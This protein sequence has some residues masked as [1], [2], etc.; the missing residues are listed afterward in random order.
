[1]PT[2][3]LIT[4]P[5]HC[6]PLCEIVKGGVCMRVLAAL[7]TIIILIAGCA[8]QRPVLYPNEHTRRVG[9]VAADQDIDD[10][11]K[12]AKEPGAAL[13]VEPG[14]QSGAI[15]DLFDKFEL[16]PGQKVFVNKCLRDKGYDPV[17]WK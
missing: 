7:G 16:S 8:T 3:S 17:G 12:R 10:C 2:T 11:I 6:R 13:V 9:K 5:F 14:N 15:S 4:E 1:M